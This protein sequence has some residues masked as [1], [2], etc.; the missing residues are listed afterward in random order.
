VA[1]VFTPLPTFDFHDVPEQHARQGEA[2]EFF[3]S[4]AS[5]V[6][7]QVS[8]VPPPAGAIAFDPATGRFTYTPAAGDRLPFTLTFSTGGV[9]VAT[10]VI[11]PLPNLPNE[12]ITINYNRLL[13]DDESRDYISI[14]ESQ[15]AAEVFNDATNQTLSVDISGKTLVFDAN[16]PA[17]LHRQYNERENIKDFRLFADRVIIRSP[18][19]LPQTHVSIHARELRFEGGGLIDTTP[20]A[21]V[22]VPTGATFEDN[23]FA[24]NNGDPGHPGGDVDALVERFHA[25]PTPAIRF[26][27]RGGDGGAVGDGRV[28]LWETNFPFL[29][30]NWHKLM[31]RSGNPFCG[32]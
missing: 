25:D 19:I 27:L 26:V 21:R 29:S 6:V 14:S 15:N 32:P 31:A 12:E 4:G 24:G 16:H 8:A 2:V 17:L 20:K 11:T 3:V 30:T 28:G 9:A 10:S 13:P 1:A 22:K 18:L 23:L 5:N 7:L